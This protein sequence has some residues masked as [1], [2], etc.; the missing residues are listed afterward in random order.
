MHEVLRTEKNTAITKLTDEWKEKT[1]QYCTIRAGKGD[2]IHAG[3]RK[4]RSKSTFEIE[5]G[6]LEEIASSADDVK[7]ELVGVLQQLRSKECS[8]HCNSK[9]KDPGV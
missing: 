2:V 6:F 5:K 9:G 8:G 7:D 3:N 1:T 4:Q